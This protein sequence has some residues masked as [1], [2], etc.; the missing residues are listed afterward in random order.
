MVRQRGPR[1]ALP[2]AV[3][4]AAGRSA[5]RAAEPGSRGPRAFIHARHLARLRVLAELKVYHRAR[6]AWL[7]AI[8]RREHALARLVRLE[9]ALARRQ[10]RARLVHPRNG[11]AT[12]RLAAPRFVFELDGEWEAQTGRRRPVPLAR[13]HA[14]AARHPRITRP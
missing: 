5:A 12:Q 2:R 3:R 4:P 13:Q 14:P 10:A 8:H 7:A 6:R 1:R 9:A 11:H